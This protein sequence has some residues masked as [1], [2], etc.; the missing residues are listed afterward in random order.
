MRTSLRILT[1]LLLAMALGGCAIV[2]H[3]PLQQG[4]LLTKE[5][6]DQLKPG[7]TKSQVVTL[8]GTPSIA[9][10]FDHDRW[11]YVHAFA[12]NGGKMQVR[13]LSLFFNNDTLVRTQGS[14]FAADNAKL[15]Q[16]AKMFNKAGVDNGKGDKSSDDDND[17]NGNG[18]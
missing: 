10:P 13:K 16:Q 9:S 4:N 5:T 18:G 17:G 14:L 8:M 2:Y 1:P 12:I 3:P 11:D 6:V 7:M 15:L